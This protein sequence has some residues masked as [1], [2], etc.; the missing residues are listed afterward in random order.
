[1]QPGSHLELLD[2]CLDERCHV[3]HVDAS[4]CATARHFEI[5]RNAIQRIPNVMR[6]L[7][8][9]GRPVVIGH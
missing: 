2:R 6:Q 4:L 1:V 3:R 7:L 9:L 8:E 5:H